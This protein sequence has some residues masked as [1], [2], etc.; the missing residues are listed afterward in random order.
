MAYP[1][2]GRVVIDETRRLNMAR[3]VQ[4][5]Y[6][7]PGHKV[8]GVLEWSENF[9]IGAWVGIRKSEVTGIMV[10]EY[11]CKGEDIIYHVDIVSRR[12]NLPNRALIWYFVC[13]STDK[14]C[15]KLFFNGRVFVHQS[16]LQGLY[17][18][19]TLSRKMRDS[20]KL[21]EYLLGPND[22][23]KQLQQKHLKRFYRGK[24]TKKYQKLIKWKRRVDQIRPADI[25]R[26][27][28]T[29]SF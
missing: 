6:M 15:R 26:L 21:F 14:V 1:Q 3:L 13:P 2:Q 29:G 24:M 18:C 17:Q 16:A 10:L 28:I 9:K 27:L 19:Q 11:T 8:K 20:D 7:Q 23:Y 12:S 22:I 25:E 4:M 5:G